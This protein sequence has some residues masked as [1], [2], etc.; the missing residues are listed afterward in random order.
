MLLKLLLTNQVPF[1]LDNRFLFF[2]LQ[3]VIIKKG[4]VKK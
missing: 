2:E 3:I 1:N 4:G